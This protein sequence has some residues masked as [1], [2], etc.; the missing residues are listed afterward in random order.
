M[1]NLYG[2]NN[3]LSLSCPALSKPRCQSDLDA[4]SLNSSPTHT[5]LSS[6]FDSTSKHKTGFIG[7][8]MFLNCYSKNILSFVFI[9][10]ETL[11]TGIII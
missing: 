2:V 1:I 9:F 10:K 6:T 5:D 7:H 4:S 11:S 8:S 3:S